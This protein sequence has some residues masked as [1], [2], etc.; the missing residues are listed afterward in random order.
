MEQAPRG[1]TAEPT[2]DSADNVATHQ[3]DEFVPARWIV[4]HV[5]I[6]GRKVSR[7]TRGC[8][9]SPG[10]PGSVMPRRSRYS[11]SSSSDKSPI[12]FTTSRTLFRSFTARLATSL[13][14][15]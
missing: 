7:L 2:F 6:R 10:T 4:Y 8:H 9:S 5:Q 1:V 15:S 3:P 11:S 13:A 12:S 14:L